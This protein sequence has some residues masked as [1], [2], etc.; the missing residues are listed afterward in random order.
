VNAAMNLVGGK[1]MHR[2]NDLSKL[3]LLVLL[4]ALSTWPGLSWAGPAAPDSA[5]L[6]PVGQIGGLTWAIALQGNY[7]YVGI[8]PRLVVFD[9]SAPAAPTPVGQTPV[10]PRLVYKVAVA[11]DYAY[12]TDEEDLYIVD[13][14]DP[15]RPTVVGTAATPGYARGVA[16]A[17]SGSHVYVG[18]SYDLRVY[19]VSA[20]ASPVEVGMLTF[21]PI[22]V[23]RSIAVAGEYAYAVG[24][25]GGLH[26]VHMV[27]PA[28]PL[29][30]G[31]YDTP[32]MD[33]DV[34]VAGQ[35]AYIAADGLIVVNVSD[36]AHPAPAGSYTIPGGTAR[37]VTVG[38]SYAYVGG[39]DPLGC[40]LHVVN[41][42]NPAHPAGVG[43]LDV[44]GTP[45]G[46]AVAGS[47]VFVADDLDLLA[48]DV[49]N[50]AQPFVVALYQKTPLAYGVAMAGDYAYVA[51]HDWGLRIVDAADPASLTEVGFYDSPGNALDVAVR[52]DYA[53]LAAHNSGLRVI[54]VSDPAHPA[55]VGAYDPDAGQAFRLVLAGDYAYLADYDHNS[56]RIVDVSNPADPFPAGS[57]A[58][59]FPVKAVAVSE[60][61]LGGR[62]YAYL[63]EYEQKTMGSDSYL[64]VVDVTDPAHPASVGVL[65]NLAGAAFDLA[66]VEGAGETRYVYL[67]DGYLNVI[68]VTDPTSPTQT[69][70]MPAGYDR[71][72]EGVAVAGNRAYFAYGNGGLTVW[73]ITDP[74]LPTQL[75]VTGTPLSARDVAVREDAVMIAAWTGGLVAFAE[76]ELR[77]A[78][79]AITWLA[80]AGGDDPG[81][82]TIRVESSGRPLA[83]TATISPT[84]SWLEATPLSGTTTAEVV[85]TAGIAGLGVGQ[86]TTTL[87]ITAEAVPGSPQAIP[88][89]LTVAEQVFGN[90]MPLVLRGSR[91]P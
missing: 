80:E 41:V 30:V 66:V 8:G 64:R 2:R 78:P 47:H 3:G 29:E 33:R 77:V 35:Y 6:D 12:V 50:P 9:V 36:P 52:G 13:I 19:D 75:A 44:P 49:A 79:A 72:Y 65:H 42:N 55:E 53:Y 87:A 23:A 18:D 86:Y 26:V 14:H 28:A 40:S 56:L 5:A 10:F 37:S 67:A 4:L 60:T 88:V 82:R 21:S 27:D 71:T 1:T 46:V 68:D 74:A 25:T 76:T 73:D 31:T 61:L 39:Y 81:P 34:A 16:V 69:L 15:A 22:D 32:G 91:S 54:R 17:P 57:Y 45:V 59:P 58:A 24:W 20:P 84:V 85:L 90:Y 38:G 70:M 51:D 62:H 7:A 89:T 11:G 43:Y 48:V 63:A 83:W